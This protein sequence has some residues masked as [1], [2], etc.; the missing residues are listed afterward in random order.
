[1]HG[2]VNAFPHVHI[3]NPHACM[4]V[5][6][7]RVIPSRMVQRLV[8]HIARAHC[9][10]PLDMLLINMHAPLMHA[11]P[12]NA[13]GTA[14]AQHP[15]QGLTPITLPRS[16]HED[17]NPLQCHNQRLET[18]WLVCSIAYR[19]T[20]AACGRSPLPYSRPVITAVT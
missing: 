8:R 17:S 9:T 2:W 1:M 13:C 14:S 6:R 12:Q 15:T 4:A 18:D 16:K 7:G 11:P 10:V 3:C 5:G 19:P 20:A